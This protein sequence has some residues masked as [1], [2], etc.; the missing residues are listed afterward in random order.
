MTG[1]RS[2]D[3]HCLTLHPGAERRRHS[4]APIAL[5]VTARDGRA[6]PIQIEWEGVF[7]RREDDQERAQRGRRADSLR[8]QIAAIAVDARRFA[9]R[10]IDL[11]WEEANAEQDEVMRRIGWLLVSNGR[12]D[13]WQ[14]AYLEFNRDNSYVLGDEV[15]FLLGQPPATPVPLQGQEGDAA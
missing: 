13:L 3:R 1:P 11:T 4:E 5:T 15:R 8:A 10:L 6:A 12:Q 2:R 7:F 14:L 9:D